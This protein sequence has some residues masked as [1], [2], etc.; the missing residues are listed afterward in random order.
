[1]AVT[2]AVTSDVGRAS[3]GEASAVLIVYGSSGLLF[4]MPATDRNAVAWLWP[5]RLIPPDA[6]RVFISVFGHS[7]MRPCAG[8]RVAESLTRI[9][10]SHTIVV[11]LLWKNDPS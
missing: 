9:G 4:V 1:M 2:R 3:A 8:P 5:G 10:L 11:T 7:A 6:L